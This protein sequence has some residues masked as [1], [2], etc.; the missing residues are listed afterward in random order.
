MTQPTDPAFPVEVSMGE[1]GW[2]ERQTGPNSVMTSGLTK[3]ELFAAMAMQGFCANPNTW[4][5]THYAVAEHSVA[6]AKALIE[7]L[8][9]EEVSK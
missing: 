5:I 2:K 7:V 1:N 9:K 8:E 3:L 4:E 6:A